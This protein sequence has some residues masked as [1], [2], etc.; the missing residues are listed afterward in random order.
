VATE[1]FDQARMACVDQRQGVTDVQAGNRARR[2]TQGVGAGFGRGEGDHRAMQA[3]LHLRRDQADHAR[4]PVGIEQAGRHRSLA[5]HV[6]HHAGQRLLG[7]VGHR[8]LH[9]A[10]FRIDLLQ[11]LRDLAR[12]A[13]VFGQQQRDAQRHVFQPA[14]GIQARAKREADVGGGQPRGITAAGFDQRTQADSPAPR[15][16][17]AGPR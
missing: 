9:G 11:R 16:D 1:A 14:C 2:A 8:L 3:V 5:G 13:R 4:M 10:P 12:L 17:A 7:I 6:Q 15:A